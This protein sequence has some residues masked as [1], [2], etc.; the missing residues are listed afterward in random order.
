[1]GDFLK[2]VL[3]YAA[4]LLWGWLGIALVLISFIDFAERALDKK[5]MKPSLR[6]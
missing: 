1:M 4:K 5:F 2:Y 6:S 3:D